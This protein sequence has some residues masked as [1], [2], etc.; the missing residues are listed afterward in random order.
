MIAA[1]SWLLLLLEV[2]QLPIPRRLH[3]RAAATPIAGN[4]VMLMR[5]RLPVTILPR[6]ITELRCIVKLA[7]GNAGAVATQIRV[8]PECR[9]RYW[10]MTVTKTKEAPETHDRVRHTTGN[11]LDKQVVDLTD[12]FITSAIDL[13]SLNV[14]T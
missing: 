13:R 7:F 9:P 10:V 4:T 11:L 14:L 5:P 8:V 12:G 2:L 1:G 6:V 3:A